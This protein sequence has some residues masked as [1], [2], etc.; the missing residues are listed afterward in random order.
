MYPELLWLSIAQL[1][2]VIIFLGK[3]RKKK[4]TNEKVKMGSCRRTSYLLFE[5][6]KSLS[7]RL[8]HLTS[9]PIL[10]QEIVVI[11]F[12]SGRSHPFHK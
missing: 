3:K 7:F 8:S 10:I 9:L 11:H 6:E 2:P 12:S 1:T 5:K 4:Q